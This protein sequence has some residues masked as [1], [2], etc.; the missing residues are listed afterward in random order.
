MPALAQLL[1][2]ESEPTTIAYAARAITQLCASDEASANSARTAGAVPAL[3]EL[4]PPT[5]G[6]AAAVVASVTAALMAL[7]GHAVRT[8]GRV[9]DLVAL[10]QAAPTAA[11]AKAAARAIYNICN[12][13]SVGREE[14]QAALV[15][16]GAVEALTAELHTPR[17][18]RSSDAAAALS[19]CA[20]A[21]RNVTSRSDAAKQVALDAKAVE[22]LVAL[23]QAVPDADEVLA[24]G[25]WGYKGLYDGHV[26]GHEG[27][28]SVENAACCALWTLAQSYALGAAKCRDA[29]AIAALLT[30]VRRRGTTVEAVAKSATCALLALAQHDASH[31]SLTHGEGLLETL[32]SLARTTTTSEGLRLA[33]CLTLARVSPAYSGESEARII[34]LLEECDVAGHVKKMLT[35]A[36][37]KSNPSYLKM[38]FTA[39][40][41]CIYARLLST[42]DGTAHA[43][44]E[45]GVPALM[46]LMLKNTSGDTSA[47][48][49]ICRTLYNLSFYPELRP[50]L[51]EVGVAEALEPAA[52]VDIDSAAADP[53]RDAARGALLALGKLRDPNAKAAMVAA[54]RA[55][56]RVASLS[57]P[58][59]FASPG[60]LTATVPRFQVF[61]SHKCSDAKDFARGLYNM[62]MLRGFTAFLDFEFREELSNLEAVVQACDN[63]I[64]ILTDNVFE[65][66]WCLRELE[67]AVQGGV[68]IVLVRKDGAR[69]ADVNNQFT[70]DHPPPFLLNRLDER[71]RNAVLSIKAVLH[72][73]E[74]YDTF[75]TTLIERLVTPE[76]AAMMRMKRPA[77]AYPAARQNSVNVV[78][79]AAAAPE[80]HNVQHNAWRPL[81]AHKHQP[82]PSMLAADM[83]DM[84]ATLMTLRE[85]MA[86]LRAQTAAVTSAAADAFSRAAHASAVALDASA[87][88]CARDRATLALLPAWISA[89]GVL[90][91]V[92]LAVAAL[93]AGR[94]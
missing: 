83:A 58:Q 2:E 14:N 17:Q 22:A 3:L 34:A 35:E 84:L 7:D 52:A 69:W 21:L 64:F 50:A 47:T 41:A 94:C 91:C 70:C 76:K 28:G 6:Q 77:A 45:A 23:L 48:Q 15:E 33:A 54:E 71:V 63:F 1:R 18:E 42:S 30:V 57:S 55:C 24:E 53:A 89:V 19:F 26:D 59:L 68:N 67:A 56:G 8:A 90:S 38:R 37:N 25:A 60:S 75:C 73:D 40:E 9:P 32:E 82:P 44:A 20:Y 78:E 80:Q 10:L 12:N 66:E 43:L 13:G 87:A 31:T 61:L 62:L 86:S 39:T 11:D 79:P 51:V 27:H 36:L 92:L 85:D 4:L 5:Y 49:H 74:Y 88:A 72:S 16:A 29:G 93:R 65:S 81:A 46:V